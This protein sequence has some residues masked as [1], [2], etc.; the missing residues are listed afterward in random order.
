MA[1]LTSAFKGVSI[2]FAIAAVTTG[3]QAMLDPVGFSKSFGIPL[4]TG[5]Y[6]EK[7]E[8]VPETP[9]QGQP[10]ILAKSYISLMGVRQLATGLTILAL[11]SQQNWTGVATILAII[12]FVVA[13]TDG[14]YLSKAG[15][16]KLALFHAIPGAG[17]ALLACG[18]M[19]SGNL[20]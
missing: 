12:G 6:K 10:L 13:G 20:T 1:Y 9:V 15:S 7:V 11:A 3:V 19:H 18:A 14:L 5:L 4:R 17:I 2:V 16:R 8:K